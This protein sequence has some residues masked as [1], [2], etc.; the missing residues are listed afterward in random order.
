M[1]NYD[2]IIIGGGPAG[3]AAAVEIY[4][5]GIHNILILEREL[6][7]GGILQQCMHKGFG[8]NEFQETLTG[9]EYAQRFIDQVK[10][11]GIAYRLHTLV[12]EITK[13]K[14]VH[15]VNSKNGYEILHAKAI[16][17]AMGCRERTLEDISIPGTRPEGVIT[18]GTAQYYLNIKGYL[19]GKKVFILGSGDIGAIMARSLT[20]EG[21]QVFGVCEIMPYSSGLRRNIV[22][23]LEAYNIPLFLSHTVTEIRGKH[24]IHGITIAQVDANRKPIPG[25]E[26]DFE[27]DTLLLSVGLIPD[28]ELSK[29]ANIFLHE[30]TGGPIVNEMMETNIEGVFAC[31]NVLHVH[32]LVDFVSA[33]SKKTGQSVVRYLKDELKEHVKIEMINGFGIS[34][35]IPQSI[36]PVNVNEG[37]V[38][39]FMRTDQVFKDVTLVLLADGIVVQ[40]IKKSILVPSEMESMSFNLSLLPHNAISTLTIEV[41][42]FTN[43]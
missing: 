11:L 7:L 36:R 23:C 37:Q 31:G 27:V 43:E 14:E 28:N 34:Y 13:D 26:K 20:L 1:I 40:E 25:T 33:E 5:K 15:T 30:K 18:A 22:Q 17:L 16:V 6:Q 21:A 39:F 35:I 38:E 24:H 8:L 42:A 12:I 2:V 9:P 4:E 41:K 10:Q 19:V 29:K 32:D 3:L